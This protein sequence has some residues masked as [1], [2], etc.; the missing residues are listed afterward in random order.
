MTN[1]VRPGALELWGDGDLDWSAHTIKLV[2]LDAT[3]TYS[4][5]HDF[6]DDVGASTRVYTHTLTGK[7]NE[8]GVMSAAD[9]IVT[10]PIGDTIVQAWVYRDTGV[11]STSPLIA[12]FDQD[13]T[14]QPF[15]F[16][17][18]GVTPILID[19]PSSAYGLLSI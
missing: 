13:D 10:I 15:D 18:D 17:P 5:T 1:I 19:M 11:E 8:D 12:Y 9:A 14:G 3:Y 16:T 4:N 6:L 7:T 2:L